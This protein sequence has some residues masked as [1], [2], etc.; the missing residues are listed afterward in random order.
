[1]MVDDI[2]LSD[3]LN[4]ASQM[5]HHF[6]IFEKIERIIT[7]LAQHEQALEESR[8]GKVAIDSEI[9]RVAK[10]IEESKHRA[11]VEYKNLL[12]K[13]EEDLASK[14]KKATIDFDA[15][16]AALEVRRNDLNSAFVEQSRKLEDE[17]KILQKKVEEKQQELKVVT[18]QSE[19]AKADANVWS[20]Q[21]KVRQGK[22]ESDGK[23][24]IEQLEAEERVIKDRIVK[25]TTEWEKLKAKFL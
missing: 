8:R 10:E 20:Q 2:P 22:A 7:L 3:M 12:C 14:L 16:A 5:R 19:Q 21:W 17:R 24:K 18:Q 13:Q 1:M 9:T 23:A 25:L 4:T 11:E 15:F 6:Q